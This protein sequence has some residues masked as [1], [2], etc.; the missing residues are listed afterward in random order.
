MNDKWDQ[1]VSTIKKKKDKREA[2]IFIPREYVCGPWGLYERV[3]RLIYVNAFFPCAVKWI[4]Y[5]EQ[6]FFFKF[7]F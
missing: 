6:L 5:G 7:Y 2:F 3:F 1:V 4:F